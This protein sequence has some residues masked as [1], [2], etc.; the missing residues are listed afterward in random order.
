MSGTRGGRGVG[1]LPGRAVV[2]Y[3]GGYLVVMAGNVL[4]WPVSIRV[5]EMLPRFEGLAMVGVDPSPGVF[6]LARQ[7]GQLVG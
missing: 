7:S 5:W 2:S 1:W 4:G 3:Q 6:V